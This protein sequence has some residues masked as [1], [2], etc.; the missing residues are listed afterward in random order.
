MSIRGLDEEAYY[1]IPA[2]CYEL[3]R[4][5]PG[6]KR[7]IHTDENNQFG[8]H[9]SIR[10]VIVLDATHLKSK[11]KG[12]MFVANALD[13]NRNIYPVSF[14]IGDLETDA[15]WHWFFTKLHEAIGECPNLGN[16][17]H[18]CKLKK[19]DKM[20][21]HFEQTAKSYS[22]VEFDRY[23]RKIKGK[24]QAGLYKW[25]RAHMD[26]RRYNVMTTNIA[27]SINLVLR[28]ARMLPVYNVVDGDM[29]GLVHLTNNNCTYRKFQLAQLSCKHI[30]AVCRFLKLNV[31][32]KTSGYYTRKTWLDA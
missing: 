15:S 6:T 19:R 24:E 23:F 7:H 11:Y 16:M 14:G 9:S 2:Y 29:D 10:P 20:L 17:K 1:I 25:S 21:M 8:S 32:S 27:E 30:V 13:G 28:F 22:M 31:Y 5:N 26:E 18:T 12:V 4:M 3:E